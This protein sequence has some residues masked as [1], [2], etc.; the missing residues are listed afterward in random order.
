MEELTRLRASLQ[1]QPVR[2]RQVRPAVVATAMA[3]A[4]LVV[5]AAQRPTLPWR[6]DFDEDPLFQWL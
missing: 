4:V 6:R 2:R 1:P 3:L 5:L